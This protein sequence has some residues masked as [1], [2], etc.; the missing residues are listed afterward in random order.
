MTVK[1]GITMLF[2]AG[3]VAGVIALLM[4][5]NGEWAGF[6]GTLIVALGFIGLG[7]AAKRLFSSAEKKENSGQSTVSRVILVVFGGAGLIMLAGSLALFLDEDVPAGIG[8][9]IFGLVF[10]AAGYF[11]SRAF[12]PPK[13]ARAVSI[14][15]GT[16]DIRGVMGQSGKLEETAYVYVDESTPDDEIRK[17]QDDWEQRPWTQRSDWAEG[18][19]VQEGVSDIRLLVV[20]TVIWNIIG[21]G[22]AVYGI[23]VEWNSSEIPWFLVVFP[24]FGIAL[25][26]LCVRT[27]VRRRKFG[28]SIFH[29][30]T[31]P[32]YPGGRV[33]G[34][35]QTGVPVK[36]RS[37]QEF[38]LRFMC[39]RRTT[40]IDAEGKDRVIEE[41]LW[42]REEKVSG[43]ISHKGPGFQVPVDFAIPENLPPTRLSPENDR[44]LWLLHVKAPVKGVD[45]AAQFEVPVYGKPGN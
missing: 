37:M 5:V 28:V 27:W 43:L 39:A 38:S 32:F 35:I 20:F 25:M 9:L 41:I 15:T 36:S 45:Y 4:L 19:V 10:C 34:A 29:C 14:R 16:S 18:M 1:T 42:S 17:M 40:V 6:L 22:I 33:Q 31:M 13:G 12:A 2:I 8:M 24:A 21:W 23:G 11:G 30:N 7:W 26:Y 3:I 44:A